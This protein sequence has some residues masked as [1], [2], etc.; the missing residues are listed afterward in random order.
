MVKFEEV[1][2]K[3]VFKQQIIIFSMF[4]FP[5]GKNKKN[6]A[7]PDQDKGSTLIK[8]DETK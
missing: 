5:A 7:I 4:G 1:V 3:L 6:A 2:A 8:E